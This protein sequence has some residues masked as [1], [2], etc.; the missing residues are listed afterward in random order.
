MSKKKKTEVIEVSFDDVVRFSID[1]YV[2]RQQMKKPTKKEI[3]EF[4]RDNYPQVEFDS[5]K[6]NQAKEGRC[7]FEVASYGVRIAQCEATL[8]KD[9]WREVRS[10][11]DWVFK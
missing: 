10:H 9:Y 8:G 4:I 5:I 2:K 3:E 1:E 11:L 6:Y 7:W